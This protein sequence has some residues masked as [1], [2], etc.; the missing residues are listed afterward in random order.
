M[1]EGDLVFFHGPNFFSKLIRFGQALRFRGDRKQYAYWNHVAIVVGKSED[2]MIVEAVRNVQKNALWKNYNSID[3]DVRVVPVP[4][5]SKQDRKELVAYA[6]AQVGDKYDWLEIVSIAINC[7]FGGSIS[8]KFETAH[9]CSGLAGEA[10]ER[11]GFDFGREAADLMPADLA[12]YFDV[13]P[14][15]A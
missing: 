2:G 6:E 11:A 3:Y 12:E 9:I 4:G 10:L 8:I 15:S 7:I 14:E 5:L 1:Q 13:K